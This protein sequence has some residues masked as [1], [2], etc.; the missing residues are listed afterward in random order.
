MSKQSALKL[1]AELKAIGYTPRDV[2]VRMD[3][4]S[5]YVTIKRVGIPF[6]AIET[7][8]RRH[9]QLDHCQVT[10]ELLC[11]GSHVWIEVDWQLMRELAKPIYAELDAIGD[12]S[13]AT[14]AGVEVWRL[15]RVD[16]E[17]QRK[18]GRRDM[19]MHSISLAEHIAKLAHF[20][21]SP[22]PQKKDHLSA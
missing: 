22:A 13:G 8:A 12:N 9:R 4:S 5:L 19:W 21:N 14:I 15:N 20:G 18:P 17:V 11:G 6:A 3:G 1:R 10:G 2:S 16:F 7:M